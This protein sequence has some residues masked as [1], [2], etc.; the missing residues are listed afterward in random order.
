M[1]WI[2]LNGAVSGDCGC[3]KRDGFEGARIGIDS[4]VFE[5]L[6]SVRSEIPR[7]VT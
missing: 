1:Y 2:G 5:V 6:A 4:Y 7:F 3:N